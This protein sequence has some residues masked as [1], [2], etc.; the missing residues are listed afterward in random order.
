MG[1]NFEWISDSRALSI[2]LICVFLVFFRSGKD[3]LRHI[4]FR[5]YDSVQ[6]HIIYILCMM[7]LY[8]ILSFSSL[9]YPQFTVIFD[10]VRDTYE[11]IVLYHFFRMLVQLLNGDD[12]VTNLLESYKDTTKHFFPLD[13]ILKNKFIDNNLFLKCKYFIL[14]YCFV[15]PLISL[16]SCVLFFFG[17]YTPA[18]FTI[19]NSYLYFSVINNISISLSLY[20]LLLFNTILTKELEI[21]KPTQ[22]LLCIKIVIF[23]TFWQ[24]F[25]IDLLISYDFI[26]VGTE[27]TGLYVTETIH[28]Y[29]MCIEL[30]FIASLHHYSFGYKNIFVENNNRDY[31]DRNTYRNMINDMIKTLGLYKN[32]VLYVFI[33]LF[34][35]F[36]YSLLGT[37]NINTQDNVIN[38]LYYSLSVST[39][40]DNGGILPQSNLSRFFIITQKIIIICFI[41]YNI[42]FYINGNKKKF[43]TKHDNTTQYEILDDNI[44]VVTN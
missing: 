12:S 33:I 26:Y 1:L 27:I 8:S 3:I 32:Y 34:Y 42:Y 43:V 30:V 13:Y 38:Y 24:D 36:I 7:P 17:L 21:H 23:F 40:S 20:F 22:K 2:S 4:Q 10:I 16:L 44:T 9:I 29:F 39:F 6:I 15:K 5:I 35:T 19:Y 37:T 14:Q 41:Y 28:D 11:S 31:V 18:N 25:I